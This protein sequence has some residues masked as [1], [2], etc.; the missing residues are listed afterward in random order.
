[1]LFLSILMVDGEVCFMI[2]T[3]FSLQKLQRF[4]LNKGL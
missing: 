1:M 3:P 4:L 2:V